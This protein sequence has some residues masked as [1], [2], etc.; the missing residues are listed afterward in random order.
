MILSIPNGPCFSIQSNNLCANIDGITNEVLHIWKQNDSAYI[1]TRERLHGQ[2]SIIRLFMVTI[3]NINGKVFVSKLIEQRVKLLT[4]VD[5]RVF[6]AYYHT[7]SHYQ[8]TNVRCIDEDKIKTQDNNIDSKIS[9]KE[10]MDGFGFPNKNFLIIISDTDDAGFRSRYRDPM[11][12]TTSM[13]LIITQTECISFKNDINLQCLWYHPTMNRLIGIERKQYHLVSVGFDSKEN[14]IFV[15]NKYHWITGT[16]IQ[17]YFFDPDTDTI[18]IY[19]TLMAAS[20]FKNELVLLPV[21]SL[22]N[23]V[24]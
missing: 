3:S 4:I 5:Y 22:I 2:W 13:N 10:Q 6:G 19:K 23:D 17:H 1:V 21:S 9:S 15:V 20:K 14:K 8:S 16:G 18:V 12:R 11:Q 7:H 24:Y